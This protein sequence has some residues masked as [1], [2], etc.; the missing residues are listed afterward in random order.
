VHVGG[1]G[2]PVGTRNLMQSWAHAN[3]GH[4]SYPTTHG[5]MD[6]EF[7]RMSTQ[8]R[9]PATYS[10]LA[11]SSEI[12]RDPMELS[13]VAPVGRPAALAPGV[14]VAIILDTSGGM[15]QK[16]EGQKRITIAKASMRDLVSEQLAEGVPVSLR[17][18][19]GKGKSKAAR[20]VSRLAM[21]LQP[22]DRGK[23]LKL[24]K[25]LKIGKRTATPIADALHAVGDDLS[26]VT[27]TRMVVLLTDGN[28]TCDGDP[29]AA[30]EEL[31]AS[32]VDINLN[33]VGLALDDEALK[34]QMAAWA[35]AGDGSYFDAASASELGQA[36]AN[37][38]AA[39]YRVFA[40]GDEEPIASGTVGGSSVVLDPGTYRV[41]VRTDPPVAFD[42]VLL[43]GGASVILEL[44]TEPD[45]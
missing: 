33:I 26:G 45:E 4:Y 3:G 2:R 40:L 44:P 37:A 42:D 21:P 5:E 1:T 20:C 25:K 35:A 36:L 14:G 11:G 22:L 28:E 24:V 13:V 43:G 39:P 31:Q 23:T 8:L 6:R 7:E 29:S 18:F 15:N 16:L 41:E 10:V 38:V 27:G 19:G 12:N 34:E 17:I 32:G 9:R 30:I